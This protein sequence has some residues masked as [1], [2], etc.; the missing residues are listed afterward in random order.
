MS[1]SSRHARCPFVVRPIA[2]GQY[3]FVCPRPGCGAVRI[4]PHPTYHRRCDDTDSAR[5][6]PCAHRCEVLRTELCKTCGGRVRIKVYACELHGECAMASTIAG[7]A[8]CALC[9]DHVP[10][11]RPAR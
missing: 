1:D 6:G 2:D 5:G 3:Q 8:N 11:G 10:D 9:P 7:V 4:G